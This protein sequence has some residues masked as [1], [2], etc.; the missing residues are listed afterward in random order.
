MFPFPLDLNTSAK[1][2]EKLIQKSNLVFLGTIGLITLTG[3]RTKLM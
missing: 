2:K 1:T 3:T